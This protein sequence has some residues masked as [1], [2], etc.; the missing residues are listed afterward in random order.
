[1]P[2]NQKIDERNKITLE[3]DGKRVKKG[4]HDVGD[5]TQ[6]AVDELNEGAKKAIITNE[7]TLTKKQKK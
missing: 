5:A 7:I 1:M 4:F 6:R 3:V 2:T